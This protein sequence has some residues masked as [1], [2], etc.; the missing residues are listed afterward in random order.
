MKILS[1]KGF[2]G[3]KEKY[4]KLILNGAVFIY[5]TDTIY[6]IGCDAKNSRAVRKIRELKKRPTNPFSI[7]APSKK[8][9]SETCI[10]DQEAKK[11]LKK[12]PG[13]YTLIL[14]LKQ[15]KN[16]KK[17]IAKE[18]NAGSGLIG[19]RIPKNWFSDIAKKA[20]VPIVTT[21]VNEAGKQF[22]I[23]EKDVNPDIAEG[24]DF[25]IYEGEKAGKPSTLIDLSGKNAVMKKR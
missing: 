5:P 7:I 1:K 21:S 6:G 4:L 19:V 13:P 17:C 2:L 25:I 15:D 9:I 20:G 22:M 8:W 16:N 23:S 10:L 11:W 18:V 12:L 3:Q 24:V 14:K